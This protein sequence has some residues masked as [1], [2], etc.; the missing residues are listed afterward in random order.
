MN[1][2]SWLEGFLEGKE[3]LDKGDIEMI[4]TKSKEYAPITVPLTYPPALPAPY[5][6][7]TPVWSSNETE[8]TTT[9]IP[10]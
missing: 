8:I 2:N 9:S 7:Q 6:Y 10:Q 4:K 1:F 3:S 5:F